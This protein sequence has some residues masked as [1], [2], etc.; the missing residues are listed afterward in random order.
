[1]FI[2]I[3]MD[4][5]VNMYRKHNADKTENPLIETENQLIGADK[6]L[7]QSKNKL[8]EKVNQLIDTMDG[9]TNTKEN[10]RLLYEKLEDDQV[11]GR[12]DIKYNRLI[13]KSCRKSDS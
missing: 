3:G 4:F 5:R 10:I 9:N 8:I 13:N 7:I 2:E 12:K 1:M 11:F 6:Q